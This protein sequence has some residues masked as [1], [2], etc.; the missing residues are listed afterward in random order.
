MVGVRLCSELCWVRYLRTDGR[1]WGYG[2]LT[3]G[4]RGRES[5]LREDGIRRQEED[6]EEGADGMS[7]RMGSAYGM[8]AG[9]LAEEMRPPLLLT[10]VF[11]PE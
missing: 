1:K 8:L 7:E 10:A 3:Y 9:W 4:K 6:S 5:E 2:V 11:V